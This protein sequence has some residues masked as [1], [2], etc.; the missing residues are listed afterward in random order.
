M[1]QIKSSLQ[2]SYDLN[3]AKTVSCDFIAKS[4]EAE[5]ASLGVHIHPGVAYVNNRGKK[6]PEIGFKGAGGTVFAGFYP[7]WSKLSIREKQYIFDDG[8]WFN[9][10]GV[11]IP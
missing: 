1:T 2:V 10:K 8:E 4:L 11:S 3:Q 9:I 7:N 5:A 6:S